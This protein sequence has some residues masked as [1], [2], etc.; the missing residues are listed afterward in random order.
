MAQTNVK[1]LAAM[2]EKKKTIVEKPKEQNEK[3][4]I[5]KL[6]TP[7]IFGAKPKE[8]KEPLRKHTMAVGSQSSQSRDVGQLKNAFEKRQTVTIQSQDKSKFLSKAA[9]QASADTQ[10]PYSKKDAEVKTFKNAFLQNI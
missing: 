3:P 4:A 2:F 6:Q 7:S 1:D 10:N 8:T 9:E 5:G